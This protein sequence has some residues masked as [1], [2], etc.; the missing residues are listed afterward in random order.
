MFY[1]NHV[2]MLSLA[3]KELVLSAESFDTSFEKELT[4]NLET[5]FLNWIHQKVCKS[6]FGLKSRQ[7]WQ[8][9]MA[10]SFF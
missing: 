5:S 2:K 7:Q 3:D 6:E 8:S 4:S 1:N 10:F 9:G